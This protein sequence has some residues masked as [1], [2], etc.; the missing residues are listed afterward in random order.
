MHFLAQ[1]IGHCKVYSFC[2][3]TRMP[4]NLA[5]NHDLKAR[6]PEERCRKGFP[7]QDLGVRE[8]PAFDFGAVQ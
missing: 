6:R 3:R 4:R 8:N 1:V 7:G 5:S 2:T